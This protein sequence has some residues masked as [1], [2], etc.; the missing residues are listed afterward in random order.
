M[1]KTNED[2]TA[3]VP[4]PGRARPSRYHTLLKGKDMSVA[5]SYS[6]K[7]QYLLGDVMAHPDFGIGIATAIKDGTKVEVL[8]EA[9]SKVLIHGR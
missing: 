5:K 7:D 6:S 3:P 8:F 2:Q 4:R 1:A 9:G